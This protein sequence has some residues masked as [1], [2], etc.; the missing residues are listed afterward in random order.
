MDIVLP[1]IY[2]AILWWFSTGA[3]LY[4]DGLPQRTFPRS[5]A[6]GAV[7]AAAGL[8][9]LV[10]TRDATTAGSAYLAF[11]CALAVWA[12]I[13]MTFL[14]GWIT[15][16]RAAPCPA[17]CGGWKHFAHGVRAVLYHEFALLAALA[18]IMILTPGAANEVGA[19]T[20]LLLWAMRASAKL[21]LFLGVPNPGT[22]LLPP[23]MHFLRPYLRKQPMNALFPVSITAITALTLA[24]LYHG[25]R[26]ESGEHGAT[27]FLLLG[28]L[29]ALAL[30]E[31]W[32]LVLPIP[33]TLLWRLGL[34][35]HAPS[36]P[37]SE[38]LR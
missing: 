28:A 15:G 1:A 33:A 3:I 38:H 17:R 11:A 10:A 27:A 22:E 24:L 21:N 23:H 35:S 4:L 9:G 18:T 37:A 32:L 36:L 34:K 14:M 5:L 31:H 8:A 13:E 29:G 20:F 6:A 30:L 7:L 25:T 16:P 26:F 12:W 2:V 19:W